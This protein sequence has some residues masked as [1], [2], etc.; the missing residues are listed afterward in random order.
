MKRGEIYYIKSNYAETGFETKGDRPAVI[1]SNDKCN[2]FSGV[3]EVVYLTSA[4]KK[5]L[6][7]HVQIFSAL[8]PS[9]VMCEQIHSVDKARC[10]NL[11]GKL[12]EEEMEAVNHALAISLGIDDRHR[13]DANGIPMAPFEIEEETTVEI[14]AE[15]DEDDAD[16]SDADW[17]NYCARLGAERDV[18]K[19]LYTE[20]LNRLTR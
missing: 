20:L 15:E 5:P 1:V 16:A 19:E 13:Y 9:T 12:T 8:R 4:P 14:E 11:L 17:E 10:D 3:V 18:Y 6:P 7:T 2:E